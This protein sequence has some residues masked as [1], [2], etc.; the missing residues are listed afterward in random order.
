MLVGPGTLIIVGIIGG[1]GAAAAYAGGSYAK[2]RGPELTKSLRATGL[3]PM[4]PEK[5]PPLP[6]S[7]G[8]KWPGKK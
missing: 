6:R 5:G 7:L 3:S 8:L 4:S 2:Q 1:I